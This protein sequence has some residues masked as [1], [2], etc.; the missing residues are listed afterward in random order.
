ML[1]LLI[2]LASVAL[3]LAGAYSIWTRRAK[4]DYSFHDDPDLSRGETRIVE[5]APA[6]VIGVIE[7][8][9]GMFL[10]SRFVL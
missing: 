1:K 7:I 5:G 3:I 9:F 10:M 6:V 2:L 8:C 4:F